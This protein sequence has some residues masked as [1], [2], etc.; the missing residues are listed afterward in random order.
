MSQADR[1]KWEARYARPRAA[2]V[3]SVDPFL[4]EIEGD[5]PRSGRA[6]DLAGGTGRHALFLAHRGFHVTLVDISARGLSLAQTAAQEQ[7]L[8]ILTRALDLEEDPLPEGPFSLVLCT[9][10]LLSDRNWIDMASV[11][12]PGGAVVYVQPT[13][14]HL[15]RHSHPGRRFTVEF[16]DLEAAVRSA[17][18]AAVRL[19]QGWDRAGNHTARFLGRLPS[20]PPGSSGG[21]GLG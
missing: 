17:G 19:E 3:S 10:F 12:E 21:N 11:L 7:G 1:D 14:K 18:I 9:W 5:L 16:A 4:E 8:A 15:E 20:E 13:P 6:L 2:E